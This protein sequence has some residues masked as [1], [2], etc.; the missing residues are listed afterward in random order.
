MAVTPKPF[1]FAALEVQ[2]RKAAR[3]AWKEVASAYPDEQLCAFALY[4]DDGAMT[5]CPSINTSQHLAAM[6]RKHPD[7]AMYYKFAPP[8]WK[9]EAT[10]AMA[11]FSAICLK[12]RTQALS[13]QGVTAADAKTLI[14]VSP[15][16][17]MPAP[18][19]LASFK[20][21]LF[22]TCLRVLESL[23][24]DRLFEGATLVFAVSDTD[25]SAKQELAMMRRLN[26]KAVVDEFRRWTKTWAQ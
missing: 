20:R 3:Q 13:F 18:R 5:V 16:P 23:R 2:V 22:E 14:G 26:D 9:Y 15:M 8:E 6:Q 17:P 25:P 19:G 21:E 10:G 1:D 7:D 11:A 4:S 24:T 12:V